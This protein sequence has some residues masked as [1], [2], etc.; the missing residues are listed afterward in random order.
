MNSTGYN[1]FYQILNA[2]NYGVPQNRERIFVVS[3]R[4][5]LEQ[6]FDFPKGFDNGI[7]LKD[8]LEDKVDEKYYINTDRAAILISKL[9]EDGQ[10]NSNKVPCDSTIMKPKALDIANCI[11]ARYNAGIQNKQ[12]IGVA[13]AEL[14]G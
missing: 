7:R 1:N 5:D 9:E 4:K 13:V 11:T 2:K 14:E 6:T 10:L 12:S 8:I 3:I